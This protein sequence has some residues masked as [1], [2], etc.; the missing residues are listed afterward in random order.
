MLT[1]FVNL[2]E[3]IQQ[4]RKVEGDGLKPLQQPMRGSDTEKMIRF[5]LGCELVS[6]MIVTLCTTGHSKPFRQSS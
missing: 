3:D 1:E 5:V 4:N 2:S 6:S